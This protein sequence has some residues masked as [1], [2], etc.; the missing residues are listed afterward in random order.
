MAPVSVV[1]LVEYGHT[2][3]HNIRS[4]NEGVA[5]CASWVILVHSDVVV[6]GFVGNGEFLVE[7]EGVLSGF[8]H[9]DQKRD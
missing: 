3:A 9:L 7:G 6:A 1:G 2:A 8:P 5:S 4:E